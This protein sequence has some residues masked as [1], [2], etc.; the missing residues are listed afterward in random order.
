MTSNQF[1]IARLETGSSRVVLRGDEHRHLA[2]AARVRAGEE[3][4]LFDAEGTRCRAEVT[5]VGRDRTE[6]RVLGFEEPEGRRIELVLVQALLPAKKMDLIVQKAAELGCTAF[7]PATTARSLRDP[8]DRS[9]RKTERWARI[10]REATKQSKGARATGVRATSALKP[11]LKET[12]DGRKLLLSE[13]GGRPLKDVLASG[14]PGA[15]PAT[16]ILAVGPEGGW[17][18]DEEELF[19][20]AGFEAVSLGS[21][22]LK[23]ETAALAATAMILHHW[24]E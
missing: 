6:L 24:N 13:R 22:I 14:G 10:A 2:R 20:E 21:R 8:S 19:R 11:L 5:A 7:V 16:V 4:R 15:A 23:A 9:A 18:V 17:T 1:F 3:V 12:A